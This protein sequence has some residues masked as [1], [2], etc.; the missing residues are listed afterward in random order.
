MVRGGGKG[1][2]RGGEKRM[3]RGGGKGM[4]RGGGKEMV[5]GRGREWIGD[6][7][8]GRKG[9]VGDWDGEKVVKYLLTDELSRC[10]VVDF[11]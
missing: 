5:G 3:V 10:G 9:K 7:Q 11:S 8:E 6:G 1:M 2:V 4:V